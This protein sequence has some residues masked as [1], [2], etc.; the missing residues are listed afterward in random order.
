MQINAGARIH[1]LQYGQFMHTMKVLNI[2]LNRKMLANFAHSEPLTFAGICHFARI[3]EHIKPKVYSNLGYVQ[4]AV[5]T[6]KIQKPI[7]HIGKVQQTAFLRE[8][9]KNFAEIIT[10]ET[11][12]LPMYQEYVQIDRPSR[13]EQRAFV[14]QCERNRKN[15]QDADWEAKKQLINPEFPVGQR[16]ITRGAVRSHWKKVYPT[17]KRPMK[18]PSM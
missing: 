11:F 3:Q 12:K 7:K 13:V 17:K 14:E 6:Q 18:T 16:D 5:F 4:S 9:H 10:H 1:H 2:G 8:E 15:K